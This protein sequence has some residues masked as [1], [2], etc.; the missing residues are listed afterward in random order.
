MPTTTPLYDQ[1]D[2]LHV[3]MSEFE[4]ARA[5]F[6]NSRGR[7]STQLIAAVAHTQEALRAV[8]LY[9]DQGC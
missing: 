2:R 9:N 6:F 7:Q 4:A 3:L 5:E 1:A 8:R